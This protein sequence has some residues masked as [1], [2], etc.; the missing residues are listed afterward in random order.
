M[1]MLV[2]VSQFFQEKGLGTGAA[3]IHGLKYNSHRDRGVTFHPLRASK[4]IVIESEI[5]C[6]DVGPGLDVNPNQVLMKLSSEAYNK[7]SF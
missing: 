7:L 6:H 3:A 2:S 1:S 4:M 5:R